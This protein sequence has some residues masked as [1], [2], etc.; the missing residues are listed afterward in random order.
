MFHEGQDVI[1]LYDTPG[2][3]NLTVRV[4]G[5][6][7]KVTAKRV[8]IEVTK[9]RTGEKVLRSVKPDKLQLAE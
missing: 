5:V 3:W 2:G 1:W 7:K 6:V 9:E 4:K 8:V